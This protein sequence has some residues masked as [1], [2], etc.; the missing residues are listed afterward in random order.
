[1]QVADKCNIEF[2]IDVR[3]MMLKFCNNRNKQD[4]TYL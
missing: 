2:M 1:M 4:Y 3:I